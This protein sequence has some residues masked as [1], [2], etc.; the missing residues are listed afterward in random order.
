MKFAHFSHIWAKPGMTPHQRYEQLWRELAGLRRA[1]LRLFVL[2]RASFPARRKL[3]VVAEPLCG[4]R[5][6]AHQAAAHRADGLYRAALSSAAACRGDRHRRSD[7]RR[8]HGAWA[9]ARHQSDYFRPFGLDYGQRKSPTL[10]FVDYLRAAF[11]DAQPFSFH[12]QDFHTDN[13]RI[14]VPP[15]AAPASA[16]V[17]DEP[18]SA[19]ARIL[20]QERHQSRLFSGLSAR[21]RRA[22]LPQISRRLEGGR[23]RAKAEH[24]LLHGGLCRRDRRQGDRDGAVSREPRL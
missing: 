8:P 14:S 2:R 12:G 9:R 15:A 1:R 13:A 11:G 22:A 23:P 19:D 6:R 10:E 20:R 3:D 7:A 17:D 5:R 21:R 24:R 18:R 16:A 4:R